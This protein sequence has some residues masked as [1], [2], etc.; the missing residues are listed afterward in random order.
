M[1]IARKY[2]M[3]L[4]VTTLFTAIGV[5]GG[6]LSVLRSSIQREIYKRGEA[7]VDAFAMAN[8][9]LML[10]YPSE[11]ERAK[12]RLQFN[13]LAVGRNPDVL[14]ARLADKAGVIIASL[15]EAEVNTPLASAPPEPEAKP[16][17]FQSTVRYGHDVLGTFWL[18]L[19]RTP[20]E[21]AL[22]RATTRALV[23]ACGIA[24]VM[25]IFALIFVRREVRPL[26]VMQLTLAAISK[27]DFSQRVPE[28]RNDEIGELSSAFNRMLRRSE[29]FFHYVD[30][31]V[32]ERLIN[33][34]KLTKPGGREQELAVTFGD[35]RG[36]TAMSN[37][38]TADEVVHI[39]NTYF[40]LFIECV[41]H[42][43]GVVDKTMGDAIMAVFE[44]GEQEHPDTHKRR[45][46]LA[47]A[48]MQAASRILNRFLRQ[49]LAAH[50]KLPIEPREFGF[51]MATGRAIVGNMGSKRRMD[52]TVCGRIVNLA[53]RLEGLT[54]NGEV[55]IDNFTCLGAVDILKTEPL[56]PVQPKGFTE[57]EKVVPHRLIGL[58]EEEAHKMR[59]FLKRLFVFSF[60]QEM[61]MPR[62]LP[63]GE[64]QPW[65]QEAELALIKLV[66]ETPVADLYS[67]VEVETGQLMPDNVLRPLPPEQRPQAPSPPAAPPIAE[68]V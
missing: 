64:Q 43:G 57:K 52:Y 7:T 26:K 40:H 30:K 62:D 6:M 1:R 29:I 25:S 31:M 33:D 58:A 27:G 34:D 38:R 68:R 28:D 45:G 55:I 12:A 18:T 37:R 10:T 65:C 54:K 48:Y 15:N 56:P 49:R 23:F 5:F 63:V 59:I 67:R 3:F 35:M 4:L 53:S 24:A 46:A 22:K 8:A 21:V 50:D 14:N 42:W 2:P 47:I 11:P 32:V 16:Y 19:S 13:L 20:L 39:V 41:A 44:R 9:P 61:V 66:A 60:L 36:Y 17:R 51:A